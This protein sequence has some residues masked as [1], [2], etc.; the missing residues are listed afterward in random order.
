MTAQGNFK[1]I[2]QPRT[3]F[4]WLCRDQA[5]V[6]AYIADPLCG[7]I[8]TAAGYRDLASWLLHI[9]RKDWAAKVQ[10]DLPVLLISGSE[11]PVSQYGA[12]PRLVCE[13]LKAAGHDVTLKVYEGSRHEVL[14]E[15]NKEE[16]WQD[17]QSWLQR[18]AAVRSERDQA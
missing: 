12:G 2:S 1:R 16:V 13:R 3:A 11:D 4:D 8:F 9:S 10:P 17:V 6:D 14:N 18:L 15:L 5:V 7:F